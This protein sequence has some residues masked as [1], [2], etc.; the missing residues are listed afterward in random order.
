MGDFNRYG[1]LTGLYDRLREELSM[2]WR[3]EQH[4]DHV[5]YE[6]LRCLK[7]L[8]QSTLGKKALG[9]HAPAPFVDLARLLFSDK[10]PGDLPAR[11]LL[12]EMI[13]ALYDILPEKAGALTD[14]AWEG[15]WV[16]LRGEPSTDIVAAGNDNLQDS[17]DRRYVR[18]VKD[19]DSLLDS[20]GELV[21]SLMTGPPNA[22]EK[23]KVDF[24]KRVTRPRR[25]KAWVREMSDIG[26]DYFWCTAVLLIL[27]DL[28][29]VDTQ[30][31]LPHDEP[32]LAARAHRRQHC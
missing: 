15:D 13:A 9:E 29:D 2:E 19:N 12:V 3:E 11:Q 10:R 1:G 25:Y 28:A 31:I 16:V 27:E 6:L 22:K 32:N 30:D 21:A 8:A 26:R 17:A 5:L 4:D 14:E 18:K 24:M 7:A 20:T 23:E